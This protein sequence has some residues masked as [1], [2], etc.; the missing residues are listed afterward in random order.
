[1]TINKIYLNKDKKHK[2]TDHC[3]ICN[4]PSI[5]NLKDFSFCET[6]FNDCSQNTKEKNLKKVEKKE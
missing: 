6:C 2:K 5:C 4:R 3:F 1:M